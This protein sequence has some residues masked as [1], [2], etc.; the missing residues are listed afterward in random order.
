MNAEVQASSSRQEAPSGIAQATRVN[1]VA[2]LNAMPAV[3]TLRDVATQSYDRAKQSYAF[4]AVP[5]QLAEIGVQ[6]AVEKSLPVLDKFSPQLRCVDRLACRGLD[7]LE[8]VYPNVTH[9]QPLEILNDIVAFGRSKLGSV[10]EYGV[11]KAQDVKTVAGG[12]LHVATH[13]VQTLSVCT[14]QTFSYTLKALEV[15]D[16]ALDKHMAACAVAM[17]E[18]A[19]SDAP[20]FTTL[21]TLLDTVVFKAAACA[22][23][24]FVSGTTKSDTSSGFDTS[25]LPLRRILRQ[26]MNQ[27]HAARLQLRNPKCRL[28]KLPLTQP[29]EAN[30]PLISRL[31]LFHKFPTDRK[32]EKVWVN[33][34]RRVDFGFYAPE[35]KGTK[36]TDVYSPAHVCSGAAAHAGEPLSFVSG[37]DPQRE[38]ERAPST[39]NGAPSTDPRC[40]F[41]PS[42][43]YGRP[44]ARGQP[45]STA[46]NEFARFPAL[47]F[48]YTSDEYGVAHARRPP[49]TALNEFTG[50][51][52]A[53][54]T[55]VG[56][57]RP[58]YSLN[59]NDLDVTS[60]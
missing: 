21:L 31:V 56:A 24:E 15:L 28:K 22:K 41:R 4:V 59:G 49:R 30:P 60:T 1:F 29:P 13:P 16:A 17:P 12:A 57:A 26:K 54:A 36:K 45:P 39:S 43:E 52:T 55:E 19:P 18:R 20:D 46:P 42:D 33:A 2:R 44:H 35:E 7:K 25:S 32:L 23:A 14:R 6:Y 53:S 50:F 51:P 27:C 11:S 10:K 47:A 34:V 37:T 3:T 58:A 5:L 38:S 9:K 8:A 40:Q 48:G